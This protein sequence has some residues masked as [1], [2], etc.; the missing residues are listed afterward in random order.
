MGRPA[1]YLLDT[2]VLVD[3]LRPRP[4]IAL[5]QALGRVPI[6]QQFISSITVGELAFGAYRSGGSDEEV[7]YVRRV[8]GAHSILPFDRAAAFR[9]GEIAAQLRRTGATIGTPDTQIAAIALSRNLTVVTA[10][11]RHFARVP[12]LAVENWLEA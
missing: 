6:E 9:Y 2:S 8:I 3:V 5:I 7:N 1:T 11:T 4:P 10:N 12:G